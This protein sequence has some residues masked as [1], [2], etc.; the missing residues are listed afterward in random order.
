MKIGIAT[1]LAFPIAQRGD[2]V[3]A[4]ARQML[5]RP[6]PLAERHLAFQLRRKTAMLLRKQIPADVV[7]R[8][9][10]AFERAV[11]RE[12]WRMV[13]TPPPPSPDNGERRPVDD[14][15]RHAHPLSPSYAMDRG[16]P[17]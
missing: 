12:V 4:L 13:L 1:I 16:G 10:R 15:R 17:I 5:A 7:A 6:A 14:R 11:R 9:V 2:Q 8:E 3:R